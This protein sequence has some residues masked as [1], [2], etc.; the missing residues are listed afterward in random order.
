MK[1]LRMELISVGELARTVLKG[2][3]PTS[4]LSVQVENKCFWIIICIWFFS[5]AGQQASERKCGEAEVEAVGRRGGDDSGSLVLRG[6]RGNER[7]ISL[8]HHQVGGCARETGR[9][10]LGGNNLWL[11][12]VKVRDEGGQEAGGGHQGGKRNSLIGLKAFLNLIEKP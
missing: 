2:K 6:E 10:K 3:A 1:N 5:G 4:N 12:D 7:A 8:L 11:Q 9:R